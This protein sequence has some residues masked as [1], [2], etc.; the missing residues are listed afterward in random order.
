MFK[1]ILTVL[2]IPLEFIVIRRKLNPGC[3]VVCVFEKN[4]LVCEPNLKFSKS[5]VEKGH[6]Q[7]K[8]SF[9]YIFI[10]NKEKHVQLFSVSRKE[11]EPKYS[12]V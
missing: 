12:E 6:L 7:K 4:L 9:S 11:R 1:C 8:L 3:N 10:S 5:E 2:V